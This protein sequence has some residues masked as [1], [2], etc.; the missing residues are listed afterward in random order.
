[1]TMTIGEAASSL[2]VSEKTVRRRIKKGAIRAVL[3]GSPPMYR[4]DDE[5]IQRLGLNNNHSFKQEDKV[6]QTEETRQ[7]SHDEVTTKLMEQIRE[8]DRQIKELHILLQGSQEQH[9]R[10]LTE[11]KGSRGPWWWPFR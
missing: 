11:T 5:E 7:N 3:S 8:K 2:G 6:D 10:M 1:M 9:K 4:V